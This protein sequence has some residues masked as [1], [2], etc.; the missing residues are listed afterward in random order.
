MGMHP[1]FSQRLAQAHWE[2]LERE[3][4]IAQAARGAGERRFRCSPPRFLRTWYRSARTWS[5]IPG[6]VVKKEIRVEEIKP[7][8]VTTFSVL[9]EEGLVS[10]YDARFIEQFVETLERELI[11]H[12]QRNGL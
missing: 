1:F 2:S 12:S 11:H 4:K 5:L 9:Y 10:A 3:A 6:A 8:V 7:A